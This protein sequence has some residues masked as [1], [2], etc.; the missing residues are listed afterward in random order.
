MNKQWIVGAVCMGS[1]LVLVSVLAYLRLI[2][3]EIK[4]IPYYDSIGH[5]MLFGMFAF[6]AEMAFGGRKVSALGIPLSIGASLVALYAVVDESLQAF[7]AVRTFDL[8]DLG[9]G[10][11]GVVVFYLLSRKLLV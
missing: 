11:F 7:S 4:S 8:H 10:L 1:F 9:F 2:P 3:T 6:A 5:F